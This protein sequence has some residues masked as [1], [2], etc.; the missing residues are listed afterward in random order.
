M[1]S[2]FPLGRS[3]ASRRP[4]SVKTARYK[5]DRLKAPQLSWVKVAR[6][7]PRSGSA[8]W[9]AEI[10]KAELSVLPKRLWTER[11]SVRGSVQALSFAEPLGLDCR[12]EGESLHMAEAFMVCFAHHGRSFGAPLCAE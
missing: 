8:I 3:D 12:R 2:A 5:A 11:K 9:G 10:G 7:N 1:S 6:A 4:P